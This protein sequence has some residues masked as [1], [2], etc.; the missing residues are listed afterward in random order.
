MMTVKQWFLSPYSVLRV[1]L[2]TVFFYF[3]IDEVIRPHLWTGWIPGF[4]TD[5][6]L[7][8]QYPFLGIVLVIFHGL[9]ALF[10][11]CA[12]LVSPYVRIGAFGML[13]LVFPVLIFFGLNDV[14]VR[15]FAIMTGALTLLINYSSPQRDES[16]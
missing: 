6:F 3:G 16:R 8:N 9:G 12:M 4:I 11:A 5:S 10:S 15:D 1:G 2:F 7:F 13:L 14:T